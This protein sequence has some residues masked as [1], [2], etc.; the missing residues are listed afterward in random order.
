MQRGS[1]ENRKEIIY[2]NRR[3]NGFDSVLFLI[4]IINL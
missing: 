2:E 1:H 3:E 4:N